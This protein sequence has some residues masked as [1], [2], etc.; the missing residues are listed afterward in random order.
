MHPFR[1]FFSAVHDCYRFGTQSNRFGIMKKT[2]YS[3][4]HNAET[5]KTIY[6]FFHNAETVTLNLLVTLNLHICKYMSKWNFK[7]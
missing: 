2:I 4:F 1:H 6:S 7:L 5:K 3:F